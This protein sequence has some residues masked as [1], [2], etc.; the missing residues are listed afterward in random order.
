MKIPKAFVLLIITIL[1]NG[2]LKSKQRKHN[3]KRRN[4]NVNE[5]LKPTISVDVKSNFLHQLNTKKSTATNNASIDVQISN[6][7]V[8][9]TNINQQPKGS[10]TNKLL[11]NIVDNYA[12]KLVDPLNEMERKKIILNKGKRNIETIVKQSLNTLKNSV[13]KIMPTNV[14]QASNIAGTLG[15]FLAGTSTLVNGI[16]N[17]N[18]VEI[19]TE[20]SVSSATI[21]LFKKERE[22][23]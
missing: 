22:L 15:G 9:H 8:D 7:Q 18:W 21:L 11:N 20:L 23:S 13:S 3:F 16:N 1:I 5:K 10:S 19:T 6:E 4:T 12:E 14:S 2:H 17:R